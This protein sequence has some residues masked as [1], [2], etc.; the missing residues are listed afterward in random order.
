MIRATSARPAAP[1]TTP[2]AI[3]PAGAGSSSPSPVSAGALVLE[4]LFD[5]AVAPSPA[6][7]AN[8][9]PLGSSEELWVKDAEAV[10]KAVDSTVVWSLE[11]VVTYALTEEAE[12]SLSEA[13][14]EDAG[15]TI[16]EPPPLNDV[17]NGSS[18]RVRVATSPSDWVSKYKRLRSIEELE[19]VAW[20]AVLEV[21]DA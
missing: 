8:P 7:P 20:E 9:T 19:S 3:V 1:P 10:E 4:T 17:V 12:L 5:V 2:P 18:D 14:D 6:M 21:E 15:T 16:S 13:A 11:M